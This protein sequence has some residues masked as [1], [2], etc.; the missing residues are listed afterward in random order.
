MFTQKELNMV[1]KNYFYVIDI[2]D[3]IIILQSK[4][5][6]HGWHIFQIENTSTCIIYHRHEN[7]TEYHKHGYSKSLEGA[8]KQIKS[9][10]SFQIQKRW[11]GFSY[12]KVIHKMGQVPEGRR[13]KFK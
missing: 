7:Q 9:H 3:N 12:S 10:D 11:K 5:T 2:S 8:I 13:R 4:N 6:L 1:D